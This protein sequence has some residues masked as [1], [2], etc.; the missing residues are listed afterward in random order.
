MSLFHD[1]SRSKHKS[2]DN[3]VFPGCSVEEMGCQDEE[4]VEPTS[5]LINALGDEVGGVG[6]ME[7]F[8]VRELEWVV[9]LSVWHALRM[10]GI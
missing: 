9:R 1:N 10:I 2:S 5:S 4:S 8:L 3:E 7:L 6:T